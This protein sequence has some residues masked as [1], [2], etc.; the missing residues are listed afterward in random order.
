[1]L[2][3]R[4]QSSLNIVGQ[5]G[6]DLHAFFGNGVL[7]FY[8]TCVK[9]LAIKK[10]FIVSFA[11]GKLFQVQDSP[12]RVKPVTQNRVSNVSHVDTNLMC[13]SGFGFD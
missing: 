5:R 1:M 4:V 3:K 6:F 8:P 11:S 2:S 10:Q 9:G 12:I 13:P 7:E